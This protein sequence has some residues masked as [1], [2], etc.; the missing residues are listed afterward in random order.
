MEEKIRTRILR[1]I[2][3]K[4]FPGC[5]V[6]VV[7]KS[8]EV[9]V[10]PFGQFTYEADLPKIKEDTIFD[11]A[12]ITKSIPTACL[13]LKLID[14]GKLKLEERLIDFIPEFKGN[15]REEIKIKHLLTLTLEFKLN[16]LSSY[17]NEPAK[18]ILERILTAD[19]KKPPGEGF[20]YA[21]SAS[22]L[23]G[24]VIEKITKEKLDELAV[25]SFFE[26]L[27]MDRTIFWPLKKFDKNDIVPT[28]NDGW[29]G[30]DIQGEVHDESAYVFMK[31]GRTV[32]SAGL[33]S[34][35]PDL[36]KFLEML[37][38]EG[39]LDGHQYFSP[40]MVHSMHSNQLGSLDQYH[41]LGWELYQPHYMGQYCTEETF[42]KTGF[43]GC[44]VMCDVSYGVGM[45]MLSNTTYPKRKPR[46]EHINSI[47]EVRRDI[48]DIIFRPR[49]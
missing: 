49:S 9:L 42:G 24:S 29:R 13:A 5:V 30:G 1:A 19:L 10:L 45:V 34:T 33:F 12:S 11:V 21:N 32:G 18:K 40:K 23:L 26:P 28:E 39:A 37:L 20:L 47:N 14:E 31:A 27:K 43:T 4:V 2:K 25:D 3:E 16:N 22:I 7:R 48:A 44:V 46:Q 15:Y 35:V 8:G 36:L 38:N 41:G 6:G 17:K